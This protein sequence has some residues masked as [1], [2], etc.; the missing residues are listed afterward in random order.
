MISNIQKKLEIIRFMSQKGGRAS[1]IIKNF[2][3][4]KS[5]FY[6][7]I[8]KISK[9]ILV[10]NRGI[11]QI[12]ASEEEL[13]RL[14]ENIGNTTEKV[15]EPAMDLGRNEKAGNRI[16]DKGVGNETEKQGYISGVD[17]T[18]P[19]EWVIRELVSPSD[20]HT[21]VTLPKITMTEVMLT[22]SKNEGL[23]NHQLFL[24]AEVKCDLFRFSPSIER[25]GFKLSHIEATENY[26]GEFAGYP[27]RIFK[28]TITF[29][30]KRNAKQVN[31]HFV[32]NLIE[33]L[34]FKI[35]RQ[36]IS[37]KT[38]PTYFEVRMDVDGYD[39]IKLLNLLNDLVK[40]YGGRI[41]GPSTS[42]L[43]TFFYI[44]FSL[45]QEIY[46][47]YYE[48]ESHRVLESIS[49]SKGNSLPEHAIRAMEFVILKLE[50]ED[51]DLE[52]PAITDWRQVKDFLVG[53]KLNEIEAD[54]LLVMFSLYKDRKPTT[55]T[56]IISQSLPYKEDDVVGAIG[57]LAEKKFVSDS[58]GN[59]EFTPKAKRILLTFYYQVRSIE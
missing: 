46:F 28:N 43:T 7:F 12:H 34:L 55:V 57:S 37:F 33:Q 17:D 6:R 8:D 49:H 13:R 11:Y 35:T 41:Q 3:I 23:S 39:E 45:N 4:S 44:P 30:G 10:E 47:K 53:M 56:N 20:F 40:R 15:S 2:G 22:Y 31:P 59:L 24:A 42:K 21:Y 14:I 19:R 51:E 29:E 25:L 36:R 9:T 1:E 54:V 48:D 27:C 38:K 52:I 18:K 50:D 16:Y 58:Q 5:F 32:Y 26:Y